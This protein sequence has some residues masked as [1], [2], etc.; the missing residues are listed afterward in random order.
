L[1]DRVL[2]EAL[3]KPAGAPFGLLPGVGEPDKE[4]RMGGLPWP[5]EGGSAVDQS[6]VS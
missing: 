2:G 4:S 6:P 3:R 5:M 1:R